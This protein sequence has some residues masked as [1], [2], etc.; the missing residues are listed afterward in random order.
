MLSI[1]LPKG[2]HGYHS[3]R[4]PMIKFIIL[5][6]LTTALPASAALSCADVHKQAA[7]VE[8]V[9]ALGVLSDSTVAIKV[10]LRSIVPDADSSGG[11]IVVQRAIGEDR[12]DRYYITEA[13]EIDGG[14]SCEIVSITESD[15]LESV[16]QSGP[17]G[18]LSPC[19]EKL[20]QAAVSD[21]AGQLDTPNDGSP[22]VVE[23]VRFHSAQTTRGLDNNSIGGDIVLREAL[24]EDR[25]RKH[26]SFGA[27]QI[28]SSNDCNFIS[29]RE[30]TLGTSRSH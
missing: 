23:I 18:P 19:E 9:K 7:I 28:G 11:Q 8:F 30:V 6:L 1:A 16:G 15:T 12:R 27:R 26:Y 3:R 2:H 10:P 25:L 29:V 14:S 5:S 24:G 13:R 22:K 20:K 4:L 17:L 21:F